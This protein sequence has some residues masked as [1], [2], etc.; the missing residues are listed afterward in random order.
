M[1]EENVGIVRQATEAAQA[2]LQGALEGGDPGAWF[3]SEFVAEDYE[4]V[5]A[6]LAQERTVYRG[7]EGFVEFWNSFIEDFEGWSIR[8]ERFIDG[9]DNTVVV[10]I[11]QQATG[12]TSGAQVE[13]RS[14]QVHEVE[15][16]QVIRARNYAT[17]AEALEA[18]GLSE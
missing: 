1:S 4:W 12:K 6:G 14:G 9:G 5:V 3:D 11:H 8:L 18:A 17:P 7:R 10:V 13:W 16:G 2:A 15:D